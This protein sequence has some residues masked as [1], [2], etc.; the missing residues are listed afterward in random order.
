M[1]GRPKGE[2]P[3][4]HDGLIRPP[5]DGPTEPTVVHLAFSEH[6]VWCGRERR[7]LAH[8]H[9]GDP[10]DIPELVPGARPCRTCVSSWRR[11]SLQGVA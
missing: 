3:H 2:H 7:G 10:D 6:R 11:G 1:R 8:I 9:S 5:P 4:R